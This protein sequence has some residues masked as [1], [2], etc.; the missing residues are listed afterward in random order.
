MQTWGIENKNWICHYANMKP[1]FYWKGRLLWKITQ[2]LHHLC[3]DPTKSKTDLNFGI[4]CTTYGVLLQ[5][6]NPK[7]VNQ[8]LQT[9]CR[10]VV[11]KR[12]SPTQGLWGKHLSFGAD[13]SYRI[14]PRVP[15]ILFIYFFLKSP[16][17]FLAN[18][19]SAIQ[20]AAASVAL[21]QLCNVRCSDDTADIRINSRNTHKHIHMWKPS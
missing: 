21:R 10:I 15:L 4:Q 18:S 1:F 19:W 14:S 3:C 11:E 12:A 2:L 17:S 20:T 9:V 5:E 6:E 8:E 16:F 7:A 13:T